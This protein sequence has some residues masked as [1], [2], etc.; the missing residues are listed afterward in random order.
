[1]I[2]PLGQGDMTPRQELHMRQHVKRRY[3][4]S[5]VVRRALAVDKVKG[6]P[7]RRG[8]VCDEFRKMSVTC[9]RSCRKTCRKQA[10]LGQA[11]LLDVG[12]FAKLRTPQRVHAPE[13]LNEMVALIP[14]KILA[15]IQTLERAAKK[16]PR[17]FF[18]D[19]Q[20]EGEFIEAGN[21]ALKGIA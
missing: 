6:C 17:Q 10:R 19:R 14:S 4:G 20:H 7:L 8:H 5:F 1:M 9:E 3:F 18:I 12:V 15:E 2:Q 21:D 13:C 11:S 16:R